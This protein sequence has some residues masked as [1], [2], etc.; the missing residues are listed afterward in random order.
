M[1][2][3]CN[4]GAAALLTQVIKV[5]RD[6]SLHDFLP[7]AKTGQKPK[8]TLPDLLEGKAEPQRDPT[9]TWNG[10]DKAGAQGSAWYWR[11]LA[12]SSD[13]DPYRALDTAGS[14]QLDA[15]IHTMVVYPRGFHPGSLGRAYLWTCPVTN[16]DYHLVTKLLE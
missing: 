10:R 4:R 6:R 9:V 3:G 2:G 8:T 13:P 12:V 16:S 5:T 11:P 1:C 15:W 14:R 7:P